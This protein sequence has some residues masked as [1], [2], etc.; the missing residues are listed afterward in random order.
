MEIQLHT[1]GL[2]RVSMDTKEERTHV[3]DKAIF[4]NKKYEAF[5]FLCLSISKDLLFHL[6]GLKTLKEIWDKLDTLDGKQDDLRVYQLENELMSLQPSNFET[7]NDF[8]T[9][10]KHIVLLLK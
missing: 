5:G 6:S 8:F 7:L 9:K 3:I 10:F 2:Y 4:L 1:R